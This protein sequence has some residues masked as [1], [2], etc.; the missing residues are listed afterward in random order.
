MSSVTGKGVKAKQVPLGRW[1]L[2]PAFGFALLYFLLAVVLPVGALLLASL[3]TSPY[4]ASL[5]QLTES[6]A[7]SFWSLGKTLRSADFLQAVP[8]SA[9][10]AVI[11]GVV[12]TALG[13]CLSYCVYRASPRAGECWSSSPWNRSPSRPSCS[14]SVC[15]GPGRCCRCRCTERSSC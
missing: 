12:G 9:M 15:C 7:L 4:A 5:G 11:A 14:A 3:Q 6:G 8:N 2:L 10:T 13:F 1:R